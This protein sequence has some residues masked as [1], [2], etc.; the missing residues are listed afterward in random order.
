MAKRIIPDW[1]FED[2]VIFLPEE[3][4]WGAEDLGSKTSEFI[5]DETWGSDSCGLLGKNSGR[6]S[7]GYGSADPGLS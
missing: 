3:I 6:A 1:Y 4:E 5:S 7:R 2:G